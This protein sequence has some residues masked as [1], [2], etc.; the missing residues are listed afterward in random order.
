MAAGEPGFLAVVG[1]PG[2]GKTCV[3]ERLQA[4]AAGR[5]WLVLSGRA[6]EFER[7]LPFAVL[8]DALDDHLAGLDHR[9]VERVGGERLAE[10]AAIFPSLDGPAV[11][12]GALQAERYRAHRA[13]QELL[14]GLAVGRPLLLV[15]DDLHWAD[16][17]SLEVVASL[18]RRPPDG[19]VLLACAFRP[20]PA[21]QFLEAALAVAEREGRAT[22][23]DLGPLTLQDAT[24]LLTEIADP[25]LRDAVFRVSGGNPFYLAQLARQ[26]VAAPAARGGGHADARRAAVRHVDAGRGGPRPA[27][28]H[29]ARARVGRGRGRA[30][31]ARRRR[32]G[33]R[34]LRV[35]GRPRRSTSCSP[36]TSSARPTCPRQFRFRH[37]LV[38][39]AVYAHAGGGWRLA[40]HGRAAA[41]LKARGAGA[42]RA[43]APRR[44]LRAARRRGGDRAAARGRRGEL[45]RG[46]PRRRRAGC[47]PRSGSSPRTRTTRGSPGASSS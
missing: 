5:E 7:E 46:R 47:R 41:A 36:A 11:P 16:Q 25:G 8:V 14:D 26:A 20:S 30:V 15:L 23:I 28:R 45:R 12:E 3:M 9:R 27:G 40:A 24:G 22:R 38:R 4:L 32:R 19:P 18:L 43:G 42:R 35:G 10:L 6:A 34:A 21:P 29:P 13:I 37:P 2:I 17:A 33:R 39:R 31:R 1:E 44:A